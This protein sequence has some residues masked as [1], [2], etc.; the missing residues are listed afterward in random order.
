[1]DG[2]RREFLSGR[3]VLIATDVGMRR[4]QREGV[5]TELAGR[6]AAARRH[7][8]MPRRLALRIR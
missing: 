2:L 6:C 7:A 4:R 8:G 5:D 1:M 3:I